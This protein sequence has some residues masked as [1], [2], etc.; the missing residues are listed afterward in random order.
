MTNYHDTLL[1]THI[2]VQADVRYW[3]DA[4]V[5]G[6]ED[7]DGDMIF[8]RVHS[9]NSDYWHVRID[10]SKGKIENWPEEMTAS[11]HYKVCDS[12]SYWLTDLI[13]TRLAKWIDYYVPNDILCHGDTGYGDYIIL[14]VGPDGM[15]KNYN[16]AKINSE[17]WQPLPVNT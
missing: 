1:A 5:N 9:L 8:G 6:I 17:E 7:V 3:E 10:L 11:I 16:A 12:G 4:T 2:E 15:I 14:N 13:G